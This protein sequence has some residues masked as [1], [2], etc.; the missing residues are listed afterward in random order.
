MVEPLEHAVAMVEP[1]EHGGTFRACCCYGK[2][3]HD[4]LLQ[5]EYTKCIFIFLQR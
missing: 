5:S 4:L 1:L 3:M 2:A